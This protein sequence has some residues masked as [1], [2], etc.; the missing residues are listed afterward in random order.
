[1]YTTLRT[2]EQAPASELVRHEKGDFS[3]L[4]IRTVHDKA[5]TACHFHPRNGIVYPFHGPGNNK[6]GNFLSRGAISMGNYQSNRHFKEKEDLHSFPNS[7]PQAQPNSSMARFGGFPFPTEVWSNLSRLIAN[8]HVPS[9]G[10]YKHR[11]TSLQSNYQA[12]FSDASKSL[13]IH[14]SMSSR[15]PS[16]AA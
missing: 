5:S 10:V 7:S 14:P 9:K 6:N 15:N 1:L 11:Q 3:L 8:L 13:I 12:I 2:R 16:S 4:C